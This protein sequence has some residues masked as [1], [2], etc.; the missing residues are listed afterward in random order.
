MRRIPSL[1]GFRCLAPVL[2]AGAVVTILHPPA[3]AQSLWRDEV[4]RSMYADKRALAVGDILTV[5]VQESTVTAKDNKTATTRESGMDAG[6]SAFFYS[7]TASP[8][9]TRRGQLPALRWNSKNQ[10]SGGGSVANS[11]RITA[12]AAVQVI[13]V[14]P[15]RNLIIE[16]RRETVV[17]NEI[18]TMVLRGIVRPED[19]LPNNTVYSY[20]IADAKIEIIGKGTLIDSQRKGWFSRLWDK[21]TPF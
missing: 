4:S 20:N 5:L 13:E 12:R 11:E 7:P 3:Q 17:G 9:L 19:V 18:Q 21:I 8:L 10:F 6:L 2:L 15:N 14:L 1:P 16:G